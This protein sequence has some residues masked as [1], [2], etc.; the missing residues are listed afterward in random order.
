[1]E[2]SNSKK[3]DERIVRIMVAISMPERDVQLRDC[4]H[5]KSRYCANKKGELALLHEETE[6]IKG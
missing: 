4:F 2:T 5:S 6:E 3:L 1:M